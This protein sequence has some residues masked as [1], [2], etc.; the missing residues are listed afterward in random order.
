MRTNNRRTSF[1][2]ALLF[3]LAFITLSF[4]HHNDFKCH[5]SDCGICYS[6]SISHLPLF[7]G[8]FSLIVTFVCLFV[9]LLSEKISLP[10][11]KIENCFTR[12]P[13][14]LN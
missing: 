14:Y 7:L 11:L 12:G 8:A 4:H 6:I 5:S 2:L 10:H 9:F 3:V 1:L 13:P